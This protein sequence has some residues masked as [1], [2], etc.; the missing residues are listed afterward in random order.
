MRRPQR[1]KPRSE[2]PLKHIVRIFFF[3]ALIVLVLGGFVYTVLIKEQPQEA[4]IPA[5]S[6]YAPIFAEDLGQTPEAL[7][8]KYPDLLL[9]TNR[10][11]V[12]TGKHVMRGAQYT[13]WFV[14]NPNEYKAFRLQ[15]QKT[16]PHLSEPEI[17]QDFAKL[18]S[19]PVDSTCS[20]KSAYAE[21]KCHY[22]WWIR[23]NVTL[24]LYSRFL[25]ND[26][27]ELSAIST[28]T[29]LTSKHFDAVKSVLPTE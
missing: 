12:L 9:R 7:K 28:D 11:G 13:I 10:L 15:A 4:D 19:R 26:R 3:L 21:N 17:A 1:R 24:D 14:K 20:G 6:K 25:K 29:Y 16:Y 23:K 22:K 18:Y 27:V 2:N 5:N 8:A